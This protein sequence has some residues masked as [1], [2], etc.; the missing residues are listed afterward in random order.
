MSEIKTLSGKNI[1]VTGA[2]AGIG[3]Y[4]LLALAR[5]G[6]AVIGV[7]RSA[8]RCRAAEA[9]IRSEVPDA[10][11]EYLLADLSLQSQVRLLAQQ[12][13]MRLGQRGQTAL[14]ALVNN[15][16]VYS[17][18]LVRTAEGIELTLAVNHL[19]VFL[20]TL[21][22][23]PLLQAAP[24]GRVL[25]VSSNSHYRARLN[26][27]RLNRPWLYVG[28]VAYAQSK[29]ANV[30]FTTEFNRR[31][32]DSRVRAFAVDPGLVN[33][34]IGLKQGGALSRLVWASRSRLGDPPEKP[35]K[36]VLHLCQEPSLNA[37][38]DLYWRDCQP[39]ASSPQALR[40][41]LARDLWEKSL[42]LCSLETVQ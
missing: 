26:P 5:A 40:E 42:E 2:T 3:L 11:V 4:C 8:E 37:S 9:F 16:G 1:V 15:A 18:N 35:A 23:M 28:L 19:A 34:D 24:Q 13:G 38:R 14:D 10:Q 22:V 27:A 30:L 41:D 6:A 36:T 20:L 39:K 12:I 31:M 21:E 29:L 25:T 17:Q 32:Q 7:G 33:T